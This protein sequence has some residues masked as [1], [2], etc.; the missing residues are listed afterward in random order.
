MKHSTLSKHLWWAKCLFFMRSSITCYFS[1]IDC[2]WSSLSLKICCWWTWRSSSFVNSRAWTQLVRSSI[3]IA[4][5]LSLSCC[6]KWGSN[7]L[8]QCHLKSFALAVDLKITAH[9]HLFH[10]C[11]YRNFANHLANWCTCSMYTAD[12]ILLCLYDVCSFWCFCMIFKCTTHLL[13][14]CPRLFIYDHDA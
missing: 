7:T 2:Q 1:L 4:C 5:N 11:K 3:S 6:Q 8:K 12:L 14:T 13:G 10:Y 9:T